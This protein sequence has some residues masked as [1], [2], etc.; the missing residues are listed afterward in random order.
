MASVVVVLV[1][2]V[3]VGIVFVVIGFF[4]VVFVMAVF[5]VVFLDCLCHDY[6]FCGSGIQP[7]NSI[8]YCLR[9]KCIHKPMLKKTS[10]PQRKYAMP[11]DCNLRKQSSTRCVHSAL[12]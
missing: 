1:M 8:P 4:L 11:L 5:V 10:P 3:L 9:K 6:I 2:V 7:E 12:F